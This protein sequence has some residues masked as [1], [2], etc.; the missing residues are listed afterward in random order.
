MVYINPLPEAVMLIKPSI[1]SF[2][3]LKARGTNPSLTL[4]YY[5]KSDTVNVLVV[6]LLG[7]RAR[8]IHWPR[9]PCYP[10]HGG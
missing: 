5:C 2:L 1:L 6:L 3:Q 7:S 10:G 8:D 4:E 9:H